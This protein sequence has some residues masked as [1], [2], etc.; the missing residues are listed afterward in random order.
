MDEIRFIPLKM[1]PGEKGSVSHIM[2]SPDFFI[3]EVYMSTVNRNSVKGWKKHTKMTLNLAVIKGSVKFTFIKNAKTCQYTVGGK[4]YGRLV[5]APGCWVCFEGLEEENMIV[6]CADLEHDPD[7]IELRSFEGYPKD[8]SSW[9]S[10][11]VGLYEGI[12][13]KENKS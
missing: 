7:E 8:I 4:N 11:D 2:K 9:C 10:D 1:I 3:K 12:N 5:V 13:K 6:N